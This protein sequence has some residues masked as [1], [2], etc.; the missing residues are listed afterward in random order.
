MI[1]AGDI[2]GTKTILG[3]F[4]DSPAG[5]ALTRSAEFPSRDFPSLEAI[6]ERFLQ[7]VGRPTLRAACF[8]VAGPVTGGRC[9]LTNLSWRLDER[10]LAPFLRQTAG[11]AR[12]KLANDLEAAA[13]GALHLPPESFCLLNEGEP[14]ADP[15]N[16]AVIAAGTG[17]GEA[18]LFWDGSRHRPSATEGGHADFAPQGEEQIE[19]LRWMARETGGHVS[20]E[21]LLSG[22]GLV[23]LYR[24]FR[25]RCG[26]PEPAW[27]T[28][29]LV[30]G[31]GAAAV[32][33]AAME[34]ADGACARAL[35][36]FVALYGSE[37]GNLALKTLALSGVIIAGGVAPKILP[38]LKNGA[39]MRPFADKGRF[40]PMLQG[41][42]VKVVLDPQAGLLGAAWIAF[43]A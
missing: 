25:E 18:F 3:L 22:P 36:T 41:V 30:A 8:G 35:E 26:A 21:R 5:L 33:T 29:R 15:H 39:F 37:A 42:P 40:S 34:G 43:E 31:D 1:L 38:W 17:L 27:L 9:Q 28:A 2:G 6:V 12:V 19:L 10:S 24:F 13:A 32:A 20:W 23:A 7:D 11:A 4:T 14:P 16:I